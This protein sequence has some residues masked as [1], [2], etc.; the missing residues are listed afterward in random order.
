MANSRKLMLI[1]RSRATILRT[2]ISE[3]PPEVGITRIEFIGPE[4][5]IFIKNRAAIVDKLDLI[6]NVAK[7]LKKRVVVRVDSS[8]RL[9]P[10]E[11]RR[12]I[13]ELAPPEAK[14]DINSMYF[15]EEL[16]EVW[17][18]AEKPGVVIGRGAVLRHLIMAETGW[19]PIV[20]RV[21]P[22]ESKTLSTIVR[23]LLDES[24]YRYDFLR[25]I[26]ERIHRTTIYKTNYV[27]V[28][29]LGG[30]MEVGRSAVLVETKESKVLID[31]GINMGA[32]D[33]ESASPYVEGLRL[34][35]LDAVIVTHAHLD[36]CGLVPLLFKYGYRGPVYVTKPTRELMVLMLKDF[37]DVAK[38]EGKNPPYTDKDLVSTVL[39]TIP[40]D[41]EEVTDVAP[42]V[43]VT[44]YNAGHILGSAMV[45][46]H[47][48]TGLHNIVYTGDFKYTST[49]LLEKSE[50]VFPRVETLIMESTYGASK[51]QSREEAEAML[52]DIVKRTAE[53]NGVVLIPVFAVGRG[54]E[55][56]IIL[57]DAMERKLLPPM[58]VYIEGLVNEVTAVHTH[59]PEFLSKGLRARIYKGENPF[60][61]EYF[62][63]IE[64]PVARPDIV[65]D[66]P[67]VIIATSGMLT[68]GPAVEYLKLLA[69]DQR[70]SLIFV[71]YQAEGTLGRRI[72]D[73]LR[74]LQVLSA[75]NKL[76][77]IK[78]NMEIYSIDGFSGHSDQ[79]E[80]VRFVKT[81]NPKPRNIIL[82][83][84]EVAAVM[85][86]SMLLKKAVKEPKSG[87]SLDTRIYTPTNLDSLNLTAR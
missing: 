68:G 80:L 84:G 37:I 21:S 61:A 58:N 73:G 2:L 26:G 6:K 70:N 78:V 3:I 64:G 8:A 33:I 12:K 14:V 83:H 69:S 32:Q 1:D 36:H 7:K 45:H 67:S 62:K 18:W 13:A 63:I 60:I 25:L 4:I 43:K 40:L 24:R 28:T 50:S 23:Q 41:Y 56:M 39:H 46:L 65:E 20:V 59:Y 66:K 57:N 82:N 51:Q 54:Q 75:E 29:G 42:D 87:Y 11:A 85:T 44:F 17:I 86:L 15:D 35:D 53:R 77:V 31:F 71:G 30:F 19:R 72:K 48:G 10:E 38:R 74:E 49:R 27:R 34:E 81:I 79:G 52:I 5:S 22:I 16:G 9:K 55:I 47:I 76:E